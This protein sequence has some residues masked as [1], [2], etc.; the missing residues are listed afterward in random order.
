MGS[1]KFFIA[2]STNVE[3]KVAL[4]KEK[5]KSWLK[6]VSAFANGIGGSIYFGI[7]DDKK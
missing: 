4:E 7:N 1:D 5:P 3:F 2:E 6:T